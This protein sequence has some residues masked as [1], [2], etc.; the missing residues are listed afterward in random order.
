MAIKQ[1]TQEDAMGT[2]TTFDLDRFTRA[3]EERDA[4]TQL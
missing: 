4:A 2:T 1:S 3:N